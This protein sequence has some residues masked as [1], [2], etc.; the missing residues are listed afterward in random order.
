MTDLLL[1]AN[2]FVVQ[3]K[4]LDS[5]GTPSKKEKSKE[6]EISMKVMFSSKQRLRKLMGSLK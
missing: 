6:R 4:I 2:K 5:F 3:A 1:R